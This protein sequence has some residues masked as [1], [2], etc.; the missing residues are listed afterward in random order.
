MKR[1]GLMA[2][3]FIG[4]LLC[5]GCGHEHQ[6]PPLTSGE[7]MVRFFASMRKGDYENAVQLGSKLQ[8]LDTSNDLVSQLVVIQQSNQYIAMAQQAIDEHDLPRALAAIDS[9]IRAYPGNRTLPQLSRQVK[10]LRNA[11]NLLQSMAKAKSPDAMSAALT[12]AR[13]G[14]A[15]NQTPKLKK[16]F[17]DYG[18][19]LEA[20]RQAAD[21]TARP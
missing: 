3:L 2:G 10:Q 4:M 15:A 6:A 12:A 14:L 5:G 21:K 20:L 8:A 1:Y 11:E 9:G 17:E 13:I 18:K 16:Y 19:R 7:L